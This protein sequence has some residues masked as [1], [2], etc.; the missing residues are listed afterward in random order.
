VS[1]AVRCRPHVLPVFLVIALFAVLALGVFLVAFRG[2]P[3]APAHAGGRSSY[4]TR[5]AGR[6][7]F[8]VMVVGFGVVLPLLFLTGNHANASKQVGGIKLTAAAKHGREEFGHSC[9]FCH[10]LAA[11][12]AT[13]KVG[14]NLDTLRPSEQVVLNTIKNGCLQNPPSTTSPQA[15]LGFGTMPAGIIQGDDA[16]N[17]AQFVAAVAGQE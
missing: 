12:N 11:A 15:C 16:K 10:T 8:T 14:P 4:R 13:G 5:R 2:G 3:A 1:G 7:V 6:L 17:V 9:A